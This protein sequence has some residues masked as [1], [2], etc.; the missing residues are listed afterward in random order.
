[1]VRLYRRLVLSLVFVPAIALG[2]LPG[3]TLQGTAE[4]RYLGVI[5]VYRAHLHAYQPLDLQNVLDSET[6]R[7]LT[8]EYFL[9]LSAD[10]FKNGANTVL[11]RQHSP[12]ALAAVRP[13]IEK[14][15]AAYQD[16]QKGDVYSLCYDANQGATTLSLN[17]A[18][19]VSI[20]SSDFA[21]IYFGIWLG[22]K[23][24]L[25]KASRDKLLSS[26]VKSD[27]EKEHF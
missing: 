23:S 25:D 7:C 19:L 18:E 5:K 17:Q 22:P 2:S 8:L 27:Q 6:S 9:S 13:E 15:H 10:D 24:P 4:M 14:L 16:V 11:S 12:E 3:M 21:R 1:M 20:I 26:H